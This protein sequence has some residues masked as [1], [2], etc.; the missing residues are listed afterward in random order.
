MPGGRRPRTQAPTGHR[1]DLFVGT[2]V[3]G[4]LAMPHEIPAL[5]ASV[6]AI[7]CQA[8]TSMLGTLTL[9]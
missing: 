1:Q 3:A 7:F 8:H 6:N 4:L 9:R 5:P 2:L